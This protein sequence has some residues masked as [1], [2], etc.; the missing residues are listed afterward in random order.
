M[1]DWVPWVRQCLH[2][3]RRLSQLWWMCYRQVTDDGTTEVTSCGSRASEPSGSY[4]Q[5]PPP[6]QLQLQQQQP[7]D[8]GGRQHLALMS[9]AAGEMSQHERASSWL[10]NLPTE[11]SVDATS[12]AGTAATTPDQRPSAVDRATTPAGDSREPSRQ[13]L[14]LSD[15][16]LYTHISSVL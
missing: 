4:Q 2:L 5:Q 13:R 12:T 15:D 7:S 10:D 6:Q 16:T 3:G 11:S 14:F 1:P 9:A 8:A